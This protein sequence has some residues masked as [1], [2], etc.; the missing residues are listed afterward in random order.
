MLLRQPIADLIS[1]PETWAAAAAAPTGVL[2]LL[3]SV[4][5]GAL[6]GA[7][8]Y[9]PVAWS[10]V[11]EAAG[12]LVFGLLLVARGHGRDRRLP[13]HAAVAGRDRVRA[14]VDQPQA[15]RR[16]R[17]RA[18]RRGACATSSAAPGPRSSALFLIALLQNVDV[19]L[20]KRQI[21]GEAAGA[22]A[23]AAVAAKAVVWVAIG[24]G[25]YLLPEATRAARHGLGPAA[26]AGARAGRRGGRR[27]ADADRLR[28]VPGDR[29]AAGVRP[30]DG[31]GRGRAVRA[32]RAR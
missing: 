10:I 1:V 16:A 31:G 32:R 18:P 13:R 19:I 29:A 28:A 24:I 25:L 27:G 30:G 3:L 4:E 15:A 6:Q 14:V 21:G 22:Y 26:G 17:R 20:V 11:L 2:W 23:A 12:R 5:R 7:H 9:K 8:L